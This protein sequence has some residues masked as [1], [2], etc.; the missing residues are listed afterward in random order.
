[1]L[2][3]HPYSGCVVAEMATLY[4]LLPGDSEIDQLSQVCKLLGRPTHDSWPSGF[5]SVKRLLP[6]AVVS[7]GDANLDTSTFGIAMPQA[8][9][10]QRDLI[11]QLLQWEPTRR[12]NAREALHHPCLVD[13]P[14]YHGDYP[15]SVPGG[16]PPSIVATAPPTTAAAPSGST[17]TPPRIGKV[18][19]MNVIATVLRA[20]GHFKQ[21]LDRKAGHGKERS[22]RPS[23]E[24]KGR[25]SH[26]AASNSV[27]DLLEAFL[28]T[29]D[30]DGKH[31][32]GELAP[33]RSGSTNSVTDSDGL[34]ELLL[35][36]RSTSISEAN[37]PAD[38]VS[39]WVY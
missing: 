14:D 24:M 38:E 17:G 27:D 19:G 15:D 1:M 37:A 29:Y 26:Q 11:K 4:P 10:E 3:V 5:V 23:V 33:S 12:P 35:R 39:L 30:S 31:V 20:A 13:V 16:I 8:S 36:E 25:V 18:S 22:R 7:V 34:V 28:S 21:G 2:L 9:P 32:R 6:H